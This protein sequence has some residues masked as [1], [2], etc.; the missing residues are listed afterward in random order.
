MKIT[1]QQLKNLD[2]DTVLAVVDWLHDYSR[3]LELSGSCAKKSKAREE[4]DRALASCRRGCMRMV[5][6]LAEYAAGRA[7]CAEEMEIFACPRCDSCGWP[8]IE[9][10]GDQYSILCPVCAGQ[11]KTGSAAADFIKN[12]A[13]KGE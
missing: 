13:N 3:R 7:D 6:R 9:N 5:N 1:K 8:V 10:A 2:L 4:Y 12:K 11:Y